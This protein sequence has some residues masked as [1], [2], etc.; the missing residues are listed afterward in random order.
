MR[1]RV[2]SLWGQAPFKI[3]SALGWGIGLI[4]AGWPNLLQEWVASDMSAELIRSTGFW[5]LAGSTVYFAVLWILKPTSPGRGSVNFSGGVHHHHYQTLPEKLAQAIEPHPNSVP[6]APDHAVHAHS[7]TQLEPVSLQA[8]GITGLHGLYVGNIIVAAAALESEHRLDL[9][10]VGYN[11]SGVTIVISD[12][13]GWIKAGNGNIR[14]MVKL[15]RSITQGIFRS[16]PGTEFVLALRQEV[17]PEQARQYLDAFAGGR[18]V[19]MDLREFDIIVASA[20]QPEKTMRLPLWDGVNL[21]RRDDI[22]SSRSTIAAVGVAI[23]SSNAFG[24]GI[25]NQNRLHDSTNQ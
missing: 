9:A 11:G 1:E 7:A 10:I 6:I 8:S 21:R 17:S 20:A 18:H 5:F 25:A 24:V 4:S 16:E 3:L 13:A 22:V 2:Y 15:P 19:G 12:I 23:G 14:D